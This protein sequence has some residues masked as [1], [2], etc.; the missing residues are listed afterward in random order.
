[1]S[2]PFTALSEISLEI[3][4]FNAESFRLQIIQTFDAFFVP[5]A[6]LNNTYFLS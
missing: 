5:K 1:M 3:V 6:D 2:N 4:C